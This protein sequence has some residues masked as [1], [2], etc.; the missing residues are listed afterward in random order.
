MRFVT[1]TQVFD[2]SIFLNVSKFLSD[3]V[4][5]NLTGLYDMLTRLSEELEAT[6]QRQ[7]EMEEELNAAKSCKLETEKEL[8]ATKQELNSTR[9]ALK[10]GNVPK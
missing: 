3:A 9:E 7:Q 5:M 4:N 10:I 8:N 6:T 1:N 2:I